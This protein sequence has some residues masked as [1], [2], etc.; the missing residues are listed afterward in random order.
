METEA[1]GSELFTERGE[2]LDIWTATLTLTREVLAQE[3]GI[4][5]A[6]NVRVSRDGDV[7]HAESDVAANPRDALNLLGS[8]QTFTSPGVAWETKAYASFDGGWTWVDS[9]FPDQRAFGAIDA[10]AGF[11]LTGTAYMVVNR[12]TRSGNPENPIQTKGFGG[13]GIFSLVLVVVKLTVAGH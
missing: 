13:I 5:V 6:P 8:A 9:Y 3:Y 7:A 12:H 2:H 1:D 11:G 10:R 4:I